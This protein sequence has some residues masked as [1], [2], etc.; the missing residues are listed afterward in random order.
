MRAEVAIFFLI[1]FFFQGAGGIYSL[2]L[3]ARLHVLG[4]NN[5]TIQELRT[6]KLRWYEYALSASVMTML[7]A[8]LLGLTSLGYQLL[9]VGST[10]STMFFGLL[11]E[12]SFYRGTPGPSTWKQIQPHVFGWSS[13]V[14]VWA[15]LFATYFVTVNSIDASQ[16]I[17]AVI[18]SVLPG[19]FFLFTLFA[20]LQLLQIRAQRENVYF[21][22]ETAA[23]IQ[24]S[25]YKFELL[26]LI[27][28]LTT[29]VF[30]G[31]QIYRGVLSH[32]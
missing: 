32:R 1:S 9:I 31:W 14:G 11:Q 24:I 30:L 7:L 19:T 15:T 27:L 28:S 16:G 5:Q 26:Y 3:D 13:H 25:F 20:V 21:G 6:G 17:S 8:Q 10:S 12:L 4:G 18:K 22:S 2:C 23:C 29:K